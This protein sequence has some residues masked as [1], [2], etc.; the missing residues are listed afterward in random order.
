MR[1]LDQPDLAIFIARHATP[2]DSETDTYRRASFAPSVKAGKNSHIY[3]AHSYHTKVP[4]QS[5]VSYIEL[6]SDPGD[7]IIDPFCG[8]GMTGVA[9]LMAGRHA[10]HNA[11]SHL[12]RVCGR[13]RGEHSP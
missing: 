6:Y 2:Y 9:A 3:D 1:E 12:T 11:L 10:I 7:L 8:S 5:I 4:P 13:H